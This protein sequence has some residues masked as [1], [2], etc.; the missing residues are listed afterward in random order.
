MASPEERLEAL[1]QELSRRELDGFIVPSTDEHMSEYV[2]AYA[3]RLAWLTGFRGSAGTAVVLEHDAAIFVDARYSLQVNDQIEPQCWVSHTIPQTSVC[4]WLCEHAY[5]GARIGY[6]PWVH[7]NA[8]ATATRTAL[9]KRSVQLIA[10]DESPVDAI[11]RDRPSPSAAPLVAHPNELAGKSSALKRREVAATLSLFKADVTLLTALD[12]IAWLFNVRGSDVSYTPVAL[13]YALL[14]A[15][16]TAD[17]FVAPEKMTPQVRVHLGPEVRLHSRADFSAYL[18][19]LAHRKVLIDPQR[20]VAAIFRHLEESRAQIIE[21][22]DPV[23]LPKAI[24]N[25]TEICGHKAAQARDAAALARFLYWFS[26]D[27]PRGTVSELSAAERLRAFREESGLLRGLSF[28]TIS[29]FGANSAVIHYG[30]SAATDR[31]ITS[32]SLYLVD[33]GAQY[34]DGT[35]DVTRTI[36]VGR[37]TAQMRDRFTRVLRGHIAL[38]RLV[39]PLGTRGG[40]LDAFARQYLWAIGLDYPHGTGHGVGSYLGVHE[41]PHRIISP[42]AFVGGG[43][44]PLLPGMIVSNEPGYYKPGEYGMRLENLMLVV[45][46][47]I[48]GAEEKMLGFETLTFAPIDRSL[49]AIEQLAPE[50]R[51]WIDAYHAEVARI[52]APQLQREAKR[53]LID[54]TRPLG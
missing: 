20:A 21:A 39:F 24:K 17:L 32:H 7:S 25:T 33:S 28:E 38:A 27:V 13:A 19:T 10:V 48:G 26:C 5:E 46:R 14:H 4:G 54:V 37:P 49:I 12:S 41:P 2:G 9:A 50:E 35:T 52:A 15:D 6:D 31:R 40:Q 53:W 1:R 16:A 36:A 44:E 47:D 30:V 45:E 3:R 22:R 23:V 34:A 29:G 8:W 43:D 11:W 18:Q 42:Q 51:T